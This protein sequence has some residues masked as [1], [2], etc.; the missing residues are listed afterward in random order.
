MP[1]NFSSQ[2]EVAGCFIKAGDQVLF[3]K[4]LLNKPQ[5]N[6]WAIPGG[7]SD[8]GESAEET[9][10]REIRE[11]TGIE[12]QHRCLTYFGKVYIS[13]STGD[14]I[15]HIFEYNLV[16]F[17]QVKFNPKEHADYRWLTLEDALEMTLIPGEDELIKLAYGV[18]PSTSSSSNTG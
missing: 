13:H 1:R 9:V 4:R 8:R 11:E 7:K 18:Q 17:P 16:D 14:F 3:L 10:V 2:N 6:T 12:M 5:G 15:F